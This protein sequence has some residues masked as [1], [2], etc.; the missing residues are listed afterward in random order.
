MALD[1]IILDL[2]AIRATGPVASSSYVVGGE[3]LIDMGAEI[4]LGCELSLTILN[5]AGVSMSADSFDRLEVRWYMQ[6]QALS[7]AKLTTTF[8]PRAVA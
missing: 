5:Q 2:L 6:Q 1:C 8:P 4:I 3:M 7:D